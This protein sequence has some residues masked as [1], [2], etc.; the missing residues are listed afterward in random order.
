[1]SASQKKQHSFRSKKENTSMNR[2]DVL[3]ATSA[4]LAGVMGD[5]NVSAAET[6]GL[7]ESSKRENIDM[8][9][10]KAAQLKTRAI[11]ATPGGTTITPIQD[12]PPIISIRGGLNG[13]SSIKIPRVGY[14]FYKTASDNANRCMALALRSGVRH[15]DIGTLYGSNSDLSIPLKKYLDV[16]IESIDYSAE[17]P[18][19]LE[20]LDSIKKA[21]DEHAVA[22]L[23]G[24]LL[25]AASPAPLGSAGRRGRREGL[26]ISH[27]LSNAEQSSKREDV[28]RAVKRTISELGCSY[29]DMVSIH[30]PLTDESRRRETYGALI[31]LRDSGFIK[32]VGVCNYG[33]GALEEIKKNG[34]E[35][36]RYVRQATSDFI[37]FQSAFWLFYS[38]FPKKSLV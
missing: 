19:L 32:S 18:E 30:S 21:G 7:S 17:K 10:I 38:F 28:R 3:I 15:F 1:M 35:L 11:G 23:S 34:F 22:T 9:A 14:S 24:G 6:L 5:P 4:T 27:K 26:F 16:G 12:P 29:L 37:K 2:R 33:E 25:S 13:K 8:E 36:P 31:E 20:F